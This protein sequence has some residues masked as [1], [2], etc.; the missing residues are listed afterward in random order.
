[1]TSIALRFLSLFVAI[2]FL[3]MGCYTTYRITPDELASLQSGRMTPTIELDT[4]KGLVT[5]R[6][7]TPVTVRTVDGHSHNISAFNFVLNDQQLVA[8]DYD[9]LLA[10]S[11]V[12][13]AQVY[14]FNKGKTYV[15][16]AGSI[17]SAI[18]GFAAMTILAEDRN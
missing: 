2:S 15:V 12:E 10:R 9:L 7:T 17:L 8:P 14:E 3:Q 16:I 4:S 1:M 6:G 5:V 18:G 11:N 13:S